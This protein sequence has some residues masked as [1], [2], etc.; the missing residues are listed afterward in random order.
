[1][2]RVRC[3]AGTSQR[4]VEIQSANVI[5]EVPSYDMIVAWGS[6]R[7]KRSPATAKIETQHKNTVRLV[8]RM[9]CI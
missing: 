8:V 3:G 9:H 1:M 6:W 4:L 7:G 5:L 2:L